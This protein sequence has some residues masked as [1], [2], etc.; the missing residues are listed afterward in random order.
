MSF[1]TDGSARTLAGMVL[2]I[3]HNSLTAE[4]MSLRRVPVSPASSK[5]AI[6]SASVPTVLFTFMCT[7]LSRS[8]H[9]SDMRCQSV[10]FGHTLIKKMER[11][12]VS[13]LPEHQVKDCLSEVSVSGS[14]QGRGVEAS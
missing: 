1:K 8:S 4:T 13:C 6:T 12:L 7:S 5:R 11:V 9:R 14:D 10:T 3:S 2:A